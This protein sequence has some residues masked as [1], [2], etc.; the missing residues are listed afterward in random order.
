MKKFIGVLFVCCLSF[1]ITSCIHT[2]GPV[3]E[4]CGNDPLVDD[5]LDPLLGVPDLEISTSTE[6]ESC[7]D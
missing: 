4:Q 2:N 3:K 7:S 6:E 1:M 5:D